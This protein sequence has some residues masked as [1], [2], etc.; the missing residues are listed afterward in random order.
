MPTRFLRILLT[1]C[2]VTLAVSGLSAQDLDADGNPEGP[3]TSR[4]LLMFGPEDKP[5]QFIPMPMFIQNPTLGTGLGLAATF[6][7]KTDYED[8]DSPYSLISVPG[9]YTNTKSF[10]IGAFTMLYFNEDT[11]RVTVG[12][13][14]GQ[15]NN[16]YVYDFGPTVTIDQEL[17]FT[18]LYARAAYAVWPD[19]FIGAAYAIYIV[20][21]KR[22]DVNGLDGLGLV[23]S[24]FSSGIY[25]P[26]LYDG[27]NNI[28]NP[29]KGIYASLEPGF[30]PT[31]LGSDSD[32][33]TLDYGINWYAALAP[34]LILATR[35]AGSHAF[36]DVPFSSLP[37]LGRGAD[38]RGY[39]SGQYRG[40]N[41]FTFQTELRWNVIWMLNL[42][43]FGGVG[44]FYGSDSNA[45]DKNWD[46]EPFPSAGF[47]VSL[48][49]SEETGVIIRLD[50]AWGKG[51]DFAWYFQMG[52]AY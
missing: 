16:T 44:T 49:T 19:I 18:M 39:Q 33:I 23:S 5:R 32:Y 42:T 45:S 21:Y 2:L 12:G 47:G 48:L 4:S 7:F 3:E 40:N 52:H 43:A 15:V 14:Y 29:S 46:L 20:D 26:A 6:M 35:A 1:V 13:G 30:F 22:F 41:L 37:T 51:G 28:Y 50:F 24:S 27:R 9:F 10:F 17:G 34:P 36:L 38:L 11:L 25:I 8:E 31:W